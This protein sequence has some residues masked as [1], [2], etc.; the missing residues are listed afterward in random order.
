VPVPPCSPICIV[1]PR[2]ISPPDVCYFVDH[3]RL[4]YYDWGS[5]SFFFNDLKEGAR[6]ND[7]SRYPV[8]WRELSLF[9]APCF[10]PIRLCCDE[11]RDA[12]PLFLGTRPSG[13]I[14]RLLWASYSTHR[15]AEID[16][17]FLH[18]ASAWQPPMVPA[19]HYRYLQ[20]GYMQSSE[21][22]HLEGKNCGITTQSRALRC[23]IVSLRRFS[24]Q[25]KS[26]QDER[27]A[28]PVASP[29]NRPSLDSRCHGARHF[30]VEGMLQHRLCD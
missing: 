14:A 17:G 24:G 2:P 12:R 22:S 10:G 3:A 7:C 27:L 30:R 16:G 23:N 13:I 5:P 26:P 21:R 9:L 8:V 19:L 6:N 29:A 28:S 4:L 18:R 25:R 15:T 20:S 1:Q 11:S